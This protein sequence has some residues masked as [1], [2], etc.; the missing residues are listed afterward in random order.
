MRY[1]ITTTY[2]QIEKNFDKTMAF[3]AKNNLL[4]Q[5]KLRL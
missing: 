5:F 3:L 2:K 1:I 4:E